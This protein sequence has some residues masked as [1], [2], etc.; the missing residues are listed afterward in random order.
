MTYNERDGKFHVL[1]HLSWLEFKI[2]LNPFF[3]LECLKT[4]LKVL[5]CIIQYLHNIYATV[6][7]CE[8]FLPLSRMKC[9]EINF[10]S[11]I[12]II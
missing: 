2:L 11:V 4:R 1:T 8:M 6:S 3:S 9:M 5:M 7:L 12:S 10:A